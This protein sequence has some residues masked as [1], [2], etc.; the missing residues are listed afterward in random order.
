MRSGNER[1]GRGDDLA[2][3]TQRLQRCNERDGAI[4]EQGNVCNSKM[5]TKRLLQLLM[6]RTVIGELFGFPD[7]FQIRN[8]FLQRR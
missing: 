1:I 6:E 7:F 4:G 5:L 2:S 8:E 3:N